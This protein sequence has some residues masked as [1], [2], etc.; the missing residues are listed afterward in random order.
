MRPKHP[1]SVNGI[2]FDAVIESEQNYGATVPEY[3]VDSGYSV[4]DNVAITPLSLKMTLYVTATPVTWLKRHG[5]GEARIQV[6]CDELVELFTSRQLISVVSN[7]KTYSNMVIK[8]I[9]IKDT[10][11]A[12]YAREVPVEFTQVTVTYASMSSVPSAYAR[13]GTSMQSTGAAEKGS[14]PTS[15]GPGYTGAGSKYTLEDCINSSSSGGGARW[16]N[17]KSIGANIADSGVVQSLGNN[18]FEFGKKLLS[19][20]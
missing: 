16:G 10:Q 6:L 9:T 2:E 1:V 19:G 12:G 17:D 20:G 18:I 8:S 15:N 3:P 7:G 5:T 11:E 13:A 14:V 4:S